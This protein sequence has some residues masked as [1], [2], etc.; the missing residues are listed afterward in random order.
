M[1]SNVRWGWHDQG[2]IGD[3]FKIGAPGEI[4][5]IDSIRTWVVPGAAA[6]QPGHLGDAYQDVRLYFGGAASD[7]TPVSAG[8]FTAGSDEN[9]NANIRISE[10]TANG[11]TTYDDF[12]TNLRIWQV[13]FSNLGTKVRG[14]ETYRFGVWGQGREVPGETGQRF[15]W[16]N[17][18]YSA[19]LSSGAQS[20]ADGAM[21][22]FD[23]GGRFQKQFHT[24]GSG[25]DKEADINV[26]VFAHRVSGGR[27]TR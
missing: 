15:T 25:W 2:F 11:E 19:E 20:G 17:H 16:Y 8:E 26:Q 12:G 4:W 5:V 7:L 27:T 21:L 14:G 22:V 3:D 10:A 18:A 6:H 1:R 9:A 13:D 24:K 23:G